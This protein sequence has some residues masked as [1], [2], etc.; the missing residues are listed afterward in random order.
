[1]GSRRVSRDS[2]IPLYV[3]DAEPA[4]QIFLRR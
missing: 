2:E 3:E 4:K 1:M